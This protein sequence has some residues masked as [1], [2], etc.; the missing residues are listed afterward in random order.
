MKENLDEVHAEI[1]DIK[2]RDREGITKTSLKDIPEIN[3]KDWT[4]LKANLF[5]GTIQV[6]EMITSPISFALLAAPSDRAGFNLFNTLAI[7]APIAADRK[8]VV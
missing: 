7:L 1:A 3:E 8:S 5:A 4:T 6:H 2:S